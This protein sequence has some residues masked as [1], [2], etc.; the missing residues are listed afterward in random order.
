MI[1]M[2]VDGESPERR[3]FVWCRQKYGW[4]RKTWWK[5]QR[6]GLGMF[7]LSADSRAFKKAASRYRREARV[8]LVRYLGRAD[9]HS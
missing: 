9:R 3:A 6:H 7:F 8:A 2:V 5:R 1:R 4:D